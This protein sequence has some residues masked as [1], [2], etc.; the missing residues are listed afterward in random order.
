LAAIEI[1]EADP[2]ASPPAWLDTGDAV[3]G[4]IGLVRTSR[5]FAQF[6]AALS[7][8]VFL[9]HICPAD[10][11]LSVASDAADI[12]L[13]ASAA[14]TLA[15]EI[16]PKRTFSVQTRVVGTGRLPYRKVEVNEA[17]SNAVAAAT[18]AVLDAKQPHQVISVLCTEGEALIGLSDT[19]LNRSAWPGGKHRFAREEGQVSRA[20]FKLLEAVSVFALPLNAPGAAV[21][22]GAAPGGWTR[23]LRRHGWKVDAVDPAD[24]DRSL[25]RD[26]F[27]R[28]IRKRVQDYLPTAPV[29]DAIVNDLR[30]DARL[31]VDIMRDAAAHLTSSGWALMTVKLPRPVIR[32][33]D[34]RKML[35]LMH[36]DFARLSERYKITGARQLYHNRSEITIALKN[37]NDSG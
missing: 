32:V 4:R 1:R 18:G 19:A 14:L 9:A 34:A 12:P 21:D 37:R 35:S 16:D 24:L 28:H 36:R 31:S 5:S 15:K 17:V 10:I 30:M 11:T 25:L 26:T 6:A 7:Q 27:V 13:L 33:S 2:T 23:V 29:Y 3:E 20:E 22:M 8:S